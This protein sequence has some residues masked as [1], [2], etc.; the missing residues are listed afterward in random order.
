MPPLLQA[1]A[2]GSLSIGAC[3]LLAHIPMM[4]AASTL[5]QSASSPTRAPNI[6]ACQLAAFGPV[7]LRFSTWRTSAPHLR[8]AHHDSKLL[9]LGTIPYAV[10]KPYHSLARHENAGEIEEQWDVE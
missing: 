6:S 7:T 2:Q 10:M 4:G 8:L 5:R 9:Y 3:G 1:G